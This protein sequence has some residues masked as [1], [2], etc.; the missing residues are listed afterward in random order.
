MRKTISLFLAVIMVFTISAPTRT[1]AARRRFLLIGDSRL[2]GMAKT[3]DRL[4]EYYVLAQSGG[5]GK[6]NISPDGKTWTWLETYG[7]VHR[8][9]NSLTNN[10][11]SP[12]FDLAAC[13]KRQGITDIVYMMGRNV[14]DGYNYQWGIEAARMRAVE[15]ATGCNIWFGYVIPDVSSKHATNVNIIHFN[16]ELAARV[17]KS[18]R[19][20]LY[21]PM[22]NHDL[23]SR[24]GTHY[25]DYS[26]AV[27]V[28]VK[29]L[30]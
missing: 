18:R 16:K 27:D 30:R 9:V 2:V 7:N 28:L 6:R 4:S 20:N 23:L 5:S 10:T 3:D 12:S 8:K 25:S 24:D 1:C 13:A 14:I 11:S 26:D 17:K 22:K 19:I 29:T 15:R 21:T